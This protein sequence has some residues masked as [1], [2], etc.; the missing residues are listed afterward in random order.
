LPRLLVKTYAF[1]IEILVVAY[2][3]GYKRI[4]EAP[5]NI[6]WLKQNS[7]LSKSVY[8]TVIAM[9]IDT[10]AVF[11]RLKIL[12]YYDNKNKRRWVYDKDLEFKINIG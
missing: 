5:I 7:V 9:F 11:Y 4:F 3:L 10:L 8:K 12:H 2:Q 1:D 6:A